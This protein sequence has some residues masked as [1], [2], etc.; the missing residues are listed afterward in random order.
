MHVP[1]LLLPQHYPLVLLNPLTLPR[2]ALGLLLELI[3]VQLQ[4]N[5][6]IVTVAQTELVELFFQQL[7][8]SCV[9]VI[10]DLEAFDVASAVH[11]FELCLF[12]VIQND[13]FLAV[14]GLY[15]FLEPRLLKYLCDLGQ[16]SLF[17]SLE[18]R[19]LM[20][21]LVID[22]L[23]ALV[24]HCLPHLRQGLLRL[25]LILHLDEFLSDEPSGLLWQSVL[26]SALIYVQCLVEAGHHLFEVLQLHLEHGFQD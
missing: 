14:V 12:D 2:K 6:D 3:C 23:L 19:Q 11:D 25:L 5:P 15:F 20:L 18:P 10:T 4:A 24:F 9:L 17:F 7:G 21:S 16:K 26:C 1:R 22:D 13:L 8:V